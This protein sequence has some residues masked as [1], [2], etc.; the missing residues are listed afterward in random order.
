MSKSITDVVAIGHKSIN[1]HL[2]LNM[3]MWCK[4]N[5]YIYKLLKRCTLIL[6]SCF[7]FSPY[8]IL[9]LR[10]T[11]ILLW[12]AEDSYKSPQ[13]QCYRQEKI[14][15]HSKQRKNKYFFPVRSIISNLFYLLS[16]IYTAFLSTSPT[17]PVP[18]YSA[19]PPHTQFL[20]I[21]CHFASNR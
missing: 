10:P 11:N 6:A 2:K 19:Y 17:H 1:L 7:S 13:P 3:M 20:S 12:T 15:S 4:S 8:N 18:S 9:M 16:S 21:S 5:Y 14:V